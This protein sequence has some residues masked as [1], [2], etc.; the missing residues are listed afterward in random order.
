MKLIQSPWS[1]SCHKVV[2]VALEAGIPLELVNVDLF[3]G[4]A[5]TPE[6]L[7][8]NPNGRVPILEDGDFTLWE[9]NAM[10]GYIA[11]KGD[12]AD[13]SPTNPRERADVERWLTWTVVHFEAPV[14]R[15]TFERILKKMFGLGAPDE[16][17]VKA[18]SD[19]FAVSAAVLDKSLADKEYVCGRLTTADFAAAAYAAICE[20][21]GL[22]LASYP[23][24]KRWLGRMLER[25][26]MKQ[27]R[28]EAM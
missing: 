1:P 27:A 19:L 15:V 7:A 12:R 5:K 26:S 10:L 8:K 24:V 22:S 6:I 13:L 9:S 2:A 3:K 14:R 11:Q 4:G 21:A 17:I 23:N 28:R 16:A 20:H 25:E 18:N